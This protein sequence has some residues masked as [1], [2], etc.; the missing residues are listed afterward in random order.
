MRQ[1]SDQAESITVNHDQWGNE[2]PV[3]KPNHTGTTAGEGGFNFGANHYSQDW[4]GGHM[5]YG[6]T[7]NTGTNVEHTSVDVS[8]ADRGKEA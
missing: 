4:E 8:R 2:I 7:V 1:Y 3:D 5:Q 6:V